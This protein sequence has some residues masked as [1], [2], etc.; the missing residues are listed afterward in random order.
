MLSIII[1]HHKTP[2]MLRLCL[3]AIRENIVDIAHE[4]IITDSEADFESQNS[5]KGEFS[6][7]DFTFFPKNVGY[8][9]LVNAGIKKS[10]GNYVLILNAD[11]IVA[12]DSISKMIDYMESN[13]NTGLI[14]P[15]LL[16]FSNQAQNS[17]FRFPDLG[18]VLARRTL[19]GKSIWGRA[20]LNYFLI[21]DKNL[22]LPTK[23]DWLQGS[24]I[25][26]RREA[27]D[28][29]GL[30]DERFFMYLE[31]TD[32][33]RRFW[34]NNYQVIYFPGAQVFHYYY[35]ASKKWGNFLDIF[36][37]KYT[38]IHLL[39]TFKYFWKWKMS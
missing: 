13:P 23:V 12:K 36:L 31:D 10:K 33:C 2:V 16:T 3:K 25:M 39:S 27:I 5:I 32:W 34:E 29:I 9:K 11:I 18:A 7:I 24:A 6:Q 22:S 14:G 20:K 17:C 1:T 26:A 8:A 35:R 37:N 19:L 4:I 28:K 15:K 30:M 38:Q 21:K